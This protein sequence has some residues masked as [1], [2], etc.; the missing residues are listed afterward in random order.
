MILKWLFDFINNQLL[1]D[2]EKYNQI[3]LKRSVAGQMGGAQKEIKMLAKTTKQ[4]KQPKTN[5]T[6]LMKMIMKM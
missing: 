2:N 6:S 1:V 5:K 4:A 3:A